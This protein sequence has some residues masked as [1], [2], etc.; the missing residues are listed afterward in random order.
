[1]NALP[2]DI[3]ERVGKTLTS[4]DL[5]SFCRASSSMAVAVR[6]ELVKRRIHEL[7]V[8]RR[9]VHSA[10]RV[11]KTQLMRSMIRQL[12]DIQVLEHG[13]FPVVENEGSIITFTTMPEW[14][15]IEPVEGVMH[16]TCSTSS[17]LQLHANVSYGRTWHDDLVPERMWL[18]AC[19]SNIDLKKNGVVVGKWVSTRPWS[20]RNDVLLP[21]NIGFLENEFGMFW[22]EPADLLGPMSGM[23]V[24]KF[25]IAGVHPSFEDHVQITD[26]ELN[27][28]ADDPATKIFKAWTDSAVVLL[29]R[30]RTRSNNPNWLHTDYAVTTPD[31][32]ASEFP[33]EDILAAFE[34][35][36]GSGWTIEHDAFRTIRASTTWKSGELVATYD[37]ESNWR[38]IRFHDGNMT[39]MFR[40]EAPGL[41]CTIIKDGVT[42][43]DAITDDVY[44]FATLAR[45]T[46]MPVMIM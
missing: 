24:C 37:V 16:G 15:F 12:D 13:N 39:A 8:F 19:I 27:R 28:T 17:G 1:M 42:D 21:K 38:D 26:D 41:V 32:M 2:L 4:K 44:E 36:L 14:T 40:F 25:S 33:R 30:Y 45:Q 3:V 20:F 5:A 6:P 9:E 34:C 46:G 22:I 29:D 10:V 35:A 11:L 23:S 43:G 7:D 31:W 18:G